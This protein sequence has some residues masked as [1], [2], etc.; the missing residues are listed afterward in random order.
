MEFRILGPLEIGDTQSP[1]VLEAARQRALLGALLLH[2]NEAI[3]VERLI[4]ELWG[5]RPPATAAKLIHSYISQLRRRLGADLIV[6]RP[7]GYLL[8]LDDDALDGARFRRL[9][10]EGRRLALA[11]DHDRAAARYREALALWRGPP[12]ADVVF[13]SF[14]RNEVERLEEE[15]LAT[16]AD[17]IECEL[18]LGRHDQLV[19]ELEALVKQEP[20]RERVRRQLML[21]LYRA[22]RQADAL[23]AYR[24][25]RQMLGDELGVDPSPGL[26]QL[27]R[28]ILRQEPSLIIAPAR[29]KTRG[30]MPVQPTPFQGRTR[31]LRELLELLRRPEV[32]L[33]TLTGAGGSGKTRLALQAACE[34]ADEYPDGAWFVPLAP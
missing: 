30:S 8:R 7:P 14:A 27:Y 2:P 10:A 15:R 12:L 11:G 4:D 5:A 17:R 26:E 25:A 28:S 9:S 33:L 13:E 23:D 32:R 16:L 34:V 20:F 3:S 22:G 29:D 6:T 24:Q 31:E 19:P 18:A 21:A 1:I